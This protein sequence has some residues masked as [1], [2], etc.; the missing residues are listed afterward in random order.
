MPSRSTRA[1]NSNAELISPIDSPRDHARHRERPRV[2]E[3]PSEAIRF[4][5]ANE[6]SDTLGVMVREN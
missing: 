3:F 5:R 1:A 2:T 6:G 4:I